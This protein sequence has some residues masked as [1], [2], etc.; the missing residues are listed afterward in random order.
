MITRDPIRVILSLKLLI[1]KLFEFGPP[2]QKFKCTERCRQN[3]RDLLLVNAPKCLKIFR[4]IVKTD[5][6]DILQVKDVNEGCYDGNGLRE[7]ECQFFAP[8][9]KALSKQANWWIEFGFYK[10]QSMNRP[11]PSHSKKCVK[12]IYF[13]HS[14]SISN[15]WNYRPLSVC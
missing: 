12:I 9:R 13:D 4:L 5:L 1:E 7:R 10:S 6:Q 3:L 15:P 2:N 8:K 14:P 11:C